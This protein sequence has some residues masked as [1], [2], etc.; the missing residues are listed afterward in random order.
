MNGPL[1]PCEEYLRPYDLSLY[2]MRYVS[3]ETS[4]PQK[5]CAPPLGQ[6]HD[7]YRGSIDPRQE[8]KRPTSASAGPVHGP[9][10]GQHGTRL[11]LH[12]HVPCTVICVYGVTL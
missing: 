9:V 12:V 10:H 5:A 7:L 4:E 8:A 6:R 2:V 3:L 11:E 1:E